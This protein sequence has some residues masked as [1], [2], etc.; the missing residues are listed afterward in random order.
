MATDR[1]DDWGE[2]THRYWY[3]GH[4]HHQRKFEPT[5]GDCTVETFRIMAGR[6]RWHHDSGYRAGREMQAILLHKEFGETGR[7]RVTP[8]MLMAMT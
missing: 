4:L 1:P 7:N 5:G 8:E 2:S 3:T 6:D